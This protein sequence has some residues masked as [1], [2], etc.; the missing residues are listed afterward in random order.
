ME[1]R[2]LGHAV[3]GITIDSKAQ[4]YAPYIFGPSGFVIIPDARQLINS[5]PLIY[6]HLTG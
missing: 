3:F 6:N 4:Q 1:A 5:L 2:R